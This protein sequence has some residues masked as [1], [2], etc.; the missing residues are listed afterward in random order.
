[1]PLQNQILFFRGPSYGGQL[2]VLYC[3]DILPAFGFVCRYKDCVTKTLQKSPSSEDGL[4]HVSNIFVTI[5]V[6]SGAKSI[7]DIVGEKPWNDFFAKNE[8]IYFI[9]IRFLF[10]SKS[11]NAFKK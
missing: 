4:T 6:R 7:N 1:M 3:I 2:Y 8:L 9:F 10:C 11:E 5:E